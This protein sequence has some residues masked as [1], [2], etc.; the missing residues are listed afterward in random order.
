MAA[1]ALMPSLVL[2]RETAGIS[3]EWMER[4]GAGY[5]YSPWIPYSMKLPIIFFE[6]LPVANIAK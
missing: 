6:R 5:P 2:R 3:G 4:F 1:A